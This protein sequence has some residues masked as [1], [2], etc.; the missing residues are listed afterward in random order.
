[1]TA[2]ERTH[3]NTSD[4]HYAGPDR[5]GIHIIIDAA[6]ISTDR[7][8]VAA[9]RAGGEELT[10]ETAYSL[11]DAR[12]IYNQLYA[13]YVTKAT[14]KTKAPL[15][16]KYAKLRDDLR[17]VYKIGLEAAEQVD[18]GGTCN[19][20]APARRLTRWNQ[21]KVEQACREAGGDCFKWSAFNRFVLCFPIP[22]QAHKPETAADA[23]SKALSEIGYDALTYCQMD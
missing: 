3:Q 5:D 1:M 2:Y 17:S 15:T 8:E 10:M 13:R 22:G 19:M 12:R 23:M 9:I 21:S 4:L 14:E 11:N 18:D 16:G 20:D 6:E 7:F